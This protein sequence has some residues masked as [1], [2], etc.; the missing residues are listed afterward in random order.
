MN[1][2]PFTFACPSCSQHLTAEPEH[3]GQSIECPACH[4]L[5]TVPKQM[6]LAMASPPVMPAAAAQPPAPGYAAPAPM[7]SP[8]TGLV[9]AS[10]LMIGVTCLVSLI[11]GV[12]FLTWLIAAPILLVTF[13]LGIVA[14]N[15]GATTQGILILLA[16]VI[17][18]PVFLF[19]APILTTTAAV[20]GAAATAASVA[21]SATP[22]FSPSDE[23]PRP[24]AGTTSGAAGTKGSAVAIGET[25]EFGDS[26]WVVLSAREVGDSL[27][28][29]MFAKERKSDGGKFIYVR[30][31]VTNKTNEEEQILFVP[32]VRDSK[33]R[34]Y[35]ELDESEIYLPDGETGMTIEPLPAS[36]PRT[37]SALFEVASDS[38]GVVF[39]ARSLG[40]NKEEKPVDL[41]LAA[42]AQREQA[43]H[44]Q[45]AAAD[46]AKRDTDAAELAKT[47]EAAAAVEQARQ[48]R[49]DKDKLTTLKGEL[50]VLNTKIETERSRWQ[51]ATNTINRLTNN[52]RTPVQEGSQPYYQC[53]AAS[54]VI[55]EVEAGAGEL[56]AEKARLEATIQELE[57]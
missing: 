20:T 25:V 2:T 45:A 24:A 11:P 5:I 13:V 8:P 10:W 18:A 41:N 4:D 33:G 27:P 32:A 50:A 30:Y 16:S 31:K 6:M 3:I 15:K 23:S 47:R 38:T 36:L 9:I 14:L 1:P 19:V 7:Q 26:A 28:K 53:L 48:A 56:K 49:D 40:F 52:K 17:A 34:R 44:Q 21:E 55:Q 22:S 46:T 54:K 12:G 39:L 57:K 51:T 35:E 37:F 42:T 29:Q 43:V